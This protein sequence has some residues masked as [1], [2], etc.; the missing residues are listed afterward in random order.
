M[1][2][3]ECTLKD[4]QTC[5]S[6]NKA[7]CKVKDTCSLLPAKPSF[8][9]KGKCIIQK[10]QTNWSLHLFVFIKIW[11]S[12]HYSKRLTTLSFLQ[13]KIIYL[14]PE[15]S[16]N[17]DVSRNIRVIQVWWQMPKLKTA[18]WFGNLLAKAYRS[19]LNATPVLF[20]DLVQNQFLKENLAF[21]LFDYASIVCIC[22]P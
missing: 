20:W 14:Y 5:K 13:C 8:F 15:T 18:W 16:L 21:I 22:P 10:I 17:T 9:G 3:K 11:P 19:S 1:I 12:K 2:W 7:I 6:V 4:K